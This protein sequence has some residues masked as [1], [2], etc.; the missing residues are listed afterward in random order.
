MESNSKRCGWCIIEN[1]ED[2]QKIPPHQLQR[3]GIYPDRALV[4]SNFRGVD[5]LL[6][7]VVDDGTSK[8]HDL[9]VQEVKSILHDYTRQ[10]LDEATPP[11]LEHCLLS[12]SSS[13]SPEIS[14]FLGNI[15][16]FFIV[17]FRGICEILAKEALDLLRLVLLI[18]KQ[19]LMGLLVLQE[20]LDCFSLPVCWWYTLL[21]FLS[22]WTFSLPC[23]LEVVKAFIFFGG[24]QMVLGSI[25]SLAVKGGICFC[26]LCVFSLQVF[27]A[28]VVG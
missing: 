10:G 11:E 25:G 22:P 4:A 18:W 14:V 7:V 16:F 6:T 13:Q 12:L 9:G 24:D 19:H 20:G 27:C 23:Q 3:V 1:Q 26:W 5:I 15:L 21:L 8:V 2:V 17:S 28:W